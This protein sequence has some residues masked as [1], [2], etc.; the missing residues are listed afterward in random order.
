MVEKK[1]KLESSLIMKN[2]ELRNVYNEIYSKGEQEFF[3]KF[4]GGE[5]TSEINNVVF[6]SQ[7]WAGK[8]ILDLGCGT[9]HLSHL[10]AQKGAKFVYGIDFSQEAINIAK[11]RFNL[12]NLS[13]YCT[14]FI[15]WEKHVDVIIS[16]GTLEHM[17][18]PK[19][20]L[21]EMSN[22]IPIG[23]EI[24]ISSPCFLNIRGFIWMTLQTLLEVPM[25]LTDLHFIS[26]FD[27][28]EWIE[29]TPLQLISTQSFDYSTGNEFL[30]LTDL[31]KRLNN[32]LKDA[33]L[34]NSRVDRFINWL[35]KVV[36]YR[37]KNNCKQ[38]NGATALYRIRKIH[39][40]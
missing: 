36:K 40:Q 39:N 22:L 10:I 7:N 16:L 37:E 9:G 27:I 8:N 21:I 28:E 6:S 15:N 33:S 13:F 31:R 12:N 25:S 17:D 1:R 24:I 3:T 29:G 32:A 35:E 14:E 20:T 34:D 2:H 4:K 19:E 23:G 38:L 30:M 26:S 5:N 11:K 18:S